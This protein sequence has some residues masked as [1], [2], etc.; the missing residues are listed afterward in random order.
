MTHPLLG[1]RLSWAPPLPEHTASVRS[2]RVS[3]LSRALLAPTE[4]PPSI[5]HPPLWAP[6]TKCLG[7]S[8]PRGC[9]LQPPRPCF[10]P[11]SGKGPSLSDGGRGLPTPQSP[12]GVCLA[13]VSACQ[14]FYHRGV[15][16]PLWTLRGT[17]WYHRVLGT[18]PVVSHL[19]F[20]TTLRIL[21]SRKLRLS[22]TQGQVTRVGVG[23]P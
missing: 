20:P 17:H 9:L 4:L 10:C 18:L 7:T 16:P 14:P 6:G 11:R 1:A 8:R 5:C 13:S 23:G 19:S 15:R 21:P 22:D 2:Q 3:G 12:T